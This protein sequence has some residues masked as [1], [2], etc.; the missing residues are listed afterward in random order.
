MESEAA[1]HC[2]QGNQQALLQPM[3][4]VALDVAHHLCFSD[5]PPSS[6]APLPR[7]QAVLTEPGSASLKHLSYRSPV[8]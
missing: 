4:R 7:G 2:Q 1:S 5:L 3:D 6:L 8:L